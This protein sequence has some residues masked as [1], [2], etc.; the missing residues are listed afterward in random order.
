MLEGPWEPVRAMSNASAA[1][2]KPNLVRLDQQMC[3]RHLPQL[4][5]IDYRAHQL[6]YTG[7]LH[8]PPLSRRLNGFLYLRPYLAND[9]RLDLGI[10]LGVGR[11]LMGKQLA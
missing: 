7:I 10:E 9:G 2:K 5:G 4:A 8:Q 6:A 3:F 11:I 1:A